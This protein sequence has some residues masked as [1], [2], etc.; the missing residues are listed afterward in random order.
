MKVR[1]R[2]RAKGLSKDIV[3]MSYWCKM[4]HK[5]LKFSKFRMSVHVWVS[6]CHITSY[7]GIYYV[8]SSC[9]CPK[10]TRQMHASKGRSR[11]HERQQGCRN[12]TCWGIVLRSVMPSKCISSM[13]SYVATGCIFFV[14]YGPRPHIENV[15]DETSSAPTFLWIEALSSGSLDFQNSS[16]MVVAG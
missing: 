3:L 2:F 6:P 13:S 11:D 16:V 4:A 5:H 1:Q 12:I 9:T 15:A 14:Q 7:K 8:I 10:R